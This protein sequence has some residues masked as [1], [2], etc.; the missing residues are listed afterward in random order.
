MKRSIQFGLGLLL[1]ILAMGLVEAQF[2]LLR[3][4]VG[5]RPLGQREL[6]TQ[7]LGQYLAFHYPGKHAIVLSNPFTTQP[8]HPREIYQYEEAGLRG[9]RRGLGK[10]VPIE[11]VVFPDLRPEALKDP[12]SVAV[13]HNTTTPLSYLVADD[14]LD[15]LA[16]QHPGAEIL[17]SLIGLPANVRL[18][19]TWK[20][21]NPRKLAL[22]LPDLGMVGKRSAIRDT[23]K[24]GKIAAMVLNKPGAPPEDHPLGKDLQREFDQRFLLVTPETVDLCLQAYPRL[25]E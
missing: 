9:L 20:T 21:S 16:R 23:V 6:A 18:T 12:H 10:A 24:S 25:F 19:E 7:F 22:L 1:F 14:A 13:D 2:H 3:N 5:G 4:L 8:G 11:Q 15:K 17:V